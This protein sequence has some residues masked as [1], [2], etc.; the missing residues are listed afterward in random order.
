MLTLSFPKQSRRMLR[1][2]GSFAF[3]LPD[4]LSRHELVLAG[5][6]GTVSDSEGRPVPGA[7]VRLSETWLFDEFAGKRLRTPDD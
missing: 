2:V 4:G 3:V 5:L 7:V 1:R 6:Q